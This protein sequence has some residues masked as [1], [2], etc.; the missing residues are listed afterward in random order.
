M[1]Q[2][3]EHKLKELK[4]SSSRIEALTDGIF[5]FAMTLLVINLNDPQLRG[6]V[7][8]QELITNLVKMLPRFYMFLLSFALL[9]SAWGVHHRQFSYI[10]GSDNMLMWINMLRLLFVVIVP[11]STVLV[12]EY[13]N[14]PAAA[15]FFCFNMFG[16]SVV[17]YYELEY[18]VK[19]G[20]T[21]GL[22]DEHK[23]ASRLKGAYP[24]IVSSI[25]CLV[26]LIKPELSYWLFALIPLGIL[27][28][29]KLGK[30]V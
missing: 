22:P 5:A 28:M 26:A 30:V 9:A 27:F 12:G 17:S 10:K 18:A 7:T 23:K 8:N 11:F 14:L 2:H 21:E 13:G 20:F 24:V 15:F 25:A 1:E 4:F 19:K 3:K 16:L 6:L 29:K